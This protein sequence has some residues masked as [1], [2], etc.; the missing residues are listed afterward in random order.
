MLSFQRCPAAEKGELMDLDFL[1]EENV[2]FRDREEVFRSFFSFSFFPS[3]LITFVRQGGG[4]SP[5]IYCIVFPEVGYMETCNCNN[6][7]CGCNFEIHPKCDSSMVQ[8][9]N[10]GI[11]KKSYFDLLLK[12]MNVIQM[13]KMYGMS[14]QP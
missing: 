10:E 3:K 14:W 8:E 11:L 1:S 2:C 13:F 12:T 6:P 5:S 4:I 7:A 9:V